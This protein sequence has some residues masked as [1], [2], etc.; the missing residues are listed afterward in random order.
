MDLQAVCAA[1][2]STNDNFSNSFSLIK[3]EQHDFLD[4]LVIS[5]EE[6][7]DEN[8]HVCLSCNLVPS[9]LNSKISC[10]RDLGK[11]HHEGDLVTNLFTSF[12]DRILHLKNPSTQEIEM[13]L[14]LL[15]KHKE[16][17][18]PILF[19]YLGH[20]IEIDGKIN[21]PIISE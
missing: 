2:Y 10:Q 6:N 14:E 19:C 5:I 15:R 9:Q 18:K 3:Q 12:S 8:P 13:A 1:L 11:V 21:C 17:E 20:G 16:L 4:C 7:Y